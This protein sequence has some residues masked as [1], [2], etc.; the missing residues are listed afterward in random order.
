MTD[1]LNN[2]KATEVSYTSLIVSNSSEHEIPHNISISPT[3]KIGTSNASFLYNCLAD[4]Q[5]EMHDCF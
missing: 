4:E 3:T 5:I 2:N 1:M